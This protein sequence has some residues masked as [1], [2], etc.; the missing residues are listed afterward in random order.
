M[1]TEAH[2][3]LFI[4][5]HIGATHLSIRKKSGNFA[6]TM[7]YDIIP[8][9][10]RE[11]EELHL[12][13]PIYCTRM[14]EA[15]ARRVW[16]QIERVIIKDKK[17]LDAYYTT[18]ELARDLHTNTRYISAALQLFY[19]NNYMHLVN[20][21]RI[22]YACQLLKKPS[23]AAHSMEEIGLMAGYVKRQTFYK[24]FAEHKGTSPKAYR[25]AYWSKRQSKQQM[26]EASQKISE[27][28]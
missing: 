25:E 5:F 8:E 15:S 17:F 21:Y 1:P 13:L 22:Q 26:A 7:R 20:S 18:K 28:S 23:L 9:L 14:S 3:S 2:R 10:R 12:D 16:Q 4:F 11:E 6:F 24:A 19:G 27:A